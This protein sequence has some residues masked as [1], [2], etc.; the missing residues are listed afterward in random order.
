MYECQVEANYYYYLFY[1]FK[2]HLSSPLSQCNPLF[3][4]YNSAVCS[5]FY[6][7][8]VAAFRHFFYEYVNINSRVDFEKW[9]GRLH[10]DIMKLTSMPVD[11][12]FFVIQLSLPHIHWNFPNLLEHQA[13]FFLNI[14]TKLSSR[15][16]NTFFM[17]FFS[18]FC[19][20]ID[21]FLKQLKSER[22][23]GR[24]WGEHCMTCSEGPQVRFKPWATQPQPL[25]HWGN[26][27]AL[28][29]N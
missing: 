22:T 2:W 19:L 9:G 8:N 3:H 12:F 20:F 27:S 26:Q 5:W 29:T 14:F 28:P 21:L 18:L 17:F 24:G 1:F 10:P 16:L 25:S 23:W 15:C 7:L 11:V 4:V 6:Q 13:C